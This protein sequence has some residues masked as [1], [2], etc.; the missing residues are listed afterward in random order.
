MARVPLLSQEADYAELRRT[1]VR[2]GLLERRY[3]YYALRGG[4]CFALVMIWKVSTVAASA[5]RA[6][7]CETAHPATKDTIKAAAL[8]ANNFLAI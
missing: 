1:V 3:G 5:T 6:W 4:T 7:L 2:A 8:T